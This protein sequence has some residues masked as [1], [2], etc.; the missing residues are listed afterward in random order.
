MRRMLWVLSCSLGAAQMCAQSGETA[1]DAFRDSILNQQLVLRNFS[2]EAKVHAVWTGTQFAVDAP[3]WHTFGV[4]QVLTVKMKGEQIKL[5]CDRHVVLWD[6]ANSLARY[7]DGDPVEIFVDLKNGDAAQL[8]PRLRDAIFYTS[9]A[10]ALAA[11]PKPL[12]K[13]VPAHV[14]RVAPNA[15]TKPCDCSEDDP[16]ANTKDAVG[17]MYPKVIYAPDP[18]Y[19]DEGRTRKINGSIMTTLI[20]DETGRVH[21]VWVARPLGYG[22]DEEAAKTVLGYRF[23]PASCHG[24]PISVPLNVVMSFQID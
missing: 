1:F 17:Y 19:S 7:P 20:V 5:D 16:C 21:D 2:G 12:Q 10:D 3:R 15:V 9:T 14:S 4:V 22:M 6:E 8:L 18:R 11:V 13:V 24:N 23:K